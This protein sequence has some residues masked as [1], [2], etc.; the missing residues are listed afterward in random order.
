MAKP[1]PLSDESRR[2]IA[3]SVLEVDALVDE[4]LSPSEAVAKVASSKSMPL[5]HAQR[6]VQS[7]NVGMTEHIRKMGSTPEERA[8]EFELADPDK[9]AELMFPEKVPTK[10]ASVLDANIDHLLPPSAHRDRVRGA[11]TFVKEAAVA[12]DVDPRLENLFDHSKYERLRSKAFQIKQAIDEAEGELQYLAD[13]LTIKIGQLRGYFTRDDARNYHE[14]RENCSILFGG[15]ADAVFDKLVEQPIQHRALMKAAAMNRRDR[16]AVDLKQMPYKAIGE[17][18]GDAEKIVAAQR[19]LD[20]M[21]AARPSQIRGLVAQMGIPPQSRTVGVLETEV[22]KTAFFT[23]LLGSAVGS[24]IG[25]EVQQQFAKPKENLL[26]KIQRSLQDPQQDA[27]IRNI[28]IQAM[29]NDL[30][31]NDEVISAYPPQDVMRH[32]NELSQIAPRISNQDGL[33]R[34]QLRRRL[35]QGASD[36]YESEQL[37]KIENLLKRRDQPGAGVLGD[38]D[39]LV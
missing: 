34:S 14:A 33:V 23:N 38:P 32:Y 25:R 36:P 2:R 16:H 9:V 26:G 20:D 5:G 4:G 8:Q 28:Q 21:R 39:G 6:M 19:Q 18:L 10:A 35:Q 3:S 12:E 13:N 27:E 15:A 37:L 11:S 31:A 1:A 7:Y 24:G 30:M 22:E 29:L 17:I